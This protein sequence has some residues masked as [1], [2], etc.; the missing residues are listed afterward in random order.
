[1]LGIMTGAFLL[2]MGLLRC[3]VR[4]ILL[5]RLGVQRALRLGFLDAVLSKATIE[6]LVLAII[7]EVPARC[8]GPGLGCRWTRGCVRVQ[9]LVAQA[10]TMFGHPPC[11]LCAG[12]NTLEVCAG[13]ATAFHL[14]DFVCL[15]A[16]NAGFQAPV[17]HAAAHQTLRFAHLARQARPK[18]TRRTQGPSNHMLHDSLVFLFGTARLRTFA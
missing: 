7:T 18:A 5:A 6:A 13:P 2:V 4:H 10:G 16:C 14:R 8:S 17:Q 11:P 3:A 9:V 15:H 1:V 12:E